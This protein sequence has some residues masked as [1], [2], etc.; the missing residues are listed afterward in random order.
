MLLLENGPKGNRTTC[1]LVCLFY[2]FVGQVSVIKAIEQ[3]DNLLLKVCM[4]VKS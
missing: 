3:S 1:F 2:K 4:L